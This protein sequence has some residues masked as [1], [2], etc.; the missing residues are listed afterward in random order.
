MTLLYV[1]IFGLLGVFSRYFIGI[2][3]KKIFNT[4]F[5][6][7]TFIINI[8]GAFLIGIVYVLGSEKNQISPELRAGIMIGFLGGFTTFSSYCLDAIKMFEN[9]KYIQGFL[10][11]SL[12]PIIGTFAAILGI[13]IARKI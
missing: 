12:S 13:L 7:D 9:L 11:I 1:G 2:I 5:P 3:F 8:L 4:S 6:Y 10:Y